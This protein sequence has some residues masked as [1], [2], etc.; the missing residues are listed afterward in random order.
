M[1]D[2]DDLRPFPGNARRGDVGA[3]KTSLQTVGQYKPIVVN[4]ATSG[5]LGAGTILAGNHT[6]QAHVELLE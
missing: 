4:Y 1:V 2:V 6:H 5:K 3:I